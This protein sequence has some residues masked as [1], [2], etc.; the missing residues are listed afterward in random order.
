L[1]TSQCTER[2]TCGGVRD[3]HSSDSWL[4]TVPAVYDVSSGEYR[5]VGTDLDWRNP[6]LC[7]CFRCS[8]IY[9][10]HQCAPVCVWLN[11]NTTDNNA[12]IY[13]AP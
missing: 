12:T 11:R 5:W 4:P 8:V 3:V 6:I 7:F 2:D 13:R 1:L 9:T 10:E